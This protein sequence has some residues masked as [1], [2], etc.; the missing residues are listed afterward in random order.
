[1]GIGGDNRRMNYVDCTEHGHRMPEGF[2]VAEE[3]VMMEAA[4]KAISAEIEVWREFA[5]GV[6]VLAWRYRA[7]AEAWD[8]YG[9][10]WRTSGGRPNHEQ[11]YLLER[12]L[13]E[14][15]ASA[16]SCIES[17]VYAIAAAL[18]SKNVAAL[19]FGPKEQRKATPR[20]LPDCLA[21]FPKAAAIADAVST[22]M[23][24]SEWKT[25]N[26]VRNRLSHR[27]NLPRIIYAAVG[28]ELPP[29]KAIE[30]DQT[31]STPRLSGDLSSVDHLMA[32]VT[33][34][35]TVLITELT[36]VLHRP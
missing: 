15:F 28:V 18:S 25:L 26:S 9:Q 22:L 34:T 32:W 1:M 27:G 36:K 30:F 8:S 3:R 35:I 23:A 13:F 5:G 21:L 2:P 10:I 19:P 12:A 33:S 14:T 29:P 7:A 6:N 17:F 24:A 31:S 11:I 16:V 4:R 20:D